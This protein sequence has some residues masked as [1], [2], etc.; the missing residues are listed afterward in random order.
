MRRPQAMIFDVDGTLADTERDGHRA[1]FNAAFREAGLD[2]EWSVER[3]GQLLAVTGGKERIRHYMA[4]SQPDFRPPMD[5]DAFVAD[6]HQRKTR[7][8]LSMLQEGQ[9]PLRPGVKRL[10]QEAESAGLTLAIAT[11]TTPDNVVYLLEAN[12]G[13]EG[14]KRFSVIAAGDIV[15]AKKPA[16][17]IYYYTLDALGLAAEA[18]VAFEDSE[19]GLRSA[20]QAGVPVFAVVNDYTRQQAFPGA[21]AVLDRFGGPGDVPEVIAG[22]VGPG[23]YV[24][25]PL[26]QELWE[27]GQR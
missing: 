3:Y 9:I 2:W 19:N 16:P 12:L 27:R 25:L 11:T 24:D 20:Q 1:A 13:Q 17:D 6:L 23:R 8:Y 21:L 7:H 14:V 4:E 5:I 18:C 15:A 26:V 10:L 22:D